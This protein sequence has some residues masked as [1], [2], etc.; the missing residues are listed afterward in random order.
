MLGKKCIERS[1]NKRARIS[2]GLLQKMREVKWRMEKPHGHTR[3][4]ALRAQNK[5][6]RAT[7]NHHQRNLNSQAHKGRKVSNSTKIRPERSSTIMRKGRRPR[8]EEAP[9]H[10]RRKWAQVARGQLLT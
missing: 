4:M 8:E 10:H 9:T 7:A 5:K 6:T 3:E 2:I 1:N